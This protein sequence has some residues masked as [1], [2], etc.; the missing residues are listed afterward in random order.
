MIKEFRE[1]ITRGNVIDLAVGIIIG[2]A[3]TAIIGSLVK[4]IIMPIIGILIGGVDFSGIIITVGSA[5]V[6]VGVFLNA[7]VQ[8]LIIAFAVFLLIKSINRMSKMGKKKEEA[9]APTTPPPPTTEELT[10]Q[11]LNR[12]NAILDKMSDEPKG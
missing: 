2:G 10:L 9:P 12:L 11:A 8:F 6:M 7:V 4:D 3:F 1:F 5:Q